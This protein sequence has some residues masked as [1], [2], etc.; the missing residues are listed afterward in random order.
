V[1]R[2]WPTE[3]AAGR[4]RA[5]RGRPRRRLRPR[6]LDAYV[7][8]FELKTARPR[9]EPAALPAWLVLHVD[10]RHDGAAAAAS[11]LLALA[12]AATEHALAIAASEASG[13]KRTSTMVKPLHAGL[14]ARNGVA[15]AVGAGGMTASRAPSTARRGFLAAMTASA[16]AEALPPISARAGRSSRPVSP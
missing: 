13:L 12:A 15:G 16:V 7:V 10:A 3:R 4:R 6:L 8:G 2:R 5:G 1:L 9:D 11:R 14:A